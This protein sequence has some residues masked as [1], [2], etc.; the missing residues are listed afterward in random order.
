ML[1]SAPGAEDALIQ[2]QAA[3]LDDPQADPAFIAEGLAI[4]DIWDL[5]SDLE[6]LDVDALWSA[7]EALLDRLSHRQA[8]VL[9]ARYWALS[10]QAQGGLDA[11]SAAARRLRN[12][13]L[14]RLCRLPAEV[15]GARAFAHFTG[16]NTL[17]DRIAAL[18]VLLH[19][20]LTPAP[21]AL[22]IFAQRYSGD[23][24]TTDKW[25]ALLASTPRAS[26][27]ETVGA[28]LSG[29]HW[30]PTNP[31][32][33]R[34]VLGAFARNN[35]R[36]FPSCRWHRLC[37]AAEQI[38]ALDAINPQV[39]RGC[40]RCS[41]TGGASIRAPGAAFAGPSALQP[42]LR[43]REQPRGAGQADAA[44]KLNGTARFGAQTAPNPRIQHGLPPGT[45]T[46]NSSSQAR[47]AMMRWITILLAA[48]VLTGCVTTR[49]VVYR[50]PYHGAPG[51]S[52][53]GGG[54]YYDPGYA[55]SGDYYY[56]SASYGGYA[57]YG[58]SYGISYFDY[59]LYYS[60]FW[61]I[62][63]WYSTIPSCTRATTMA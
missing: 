46:R 8:R 28:L 2:A 7:R 6:Q 54:T 47:H 3:V 16:A 24:L 13:C 48:A 38:A 55:G 23:A 1:G 36:L 34:A 22:R 53:V 31:N 17:T 52:H 61:P 51:G 49:E 60:L 14:Q 4:P 37:A 10:A 32:R 9:D 25:L 39:A 29:P 15:D 50:E 45:E 41:S 18:G 62:N 35:V 33:V 20:G 27:L 59:P 12:L 58:V 43:S 63:R 44:M 56:G 21:T 5:S 19:R 57:G 26:A 11:A 42:Q 30:Q 40:C